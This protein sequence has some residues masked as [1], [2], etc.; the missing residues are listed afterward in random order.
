MFSRI[1]KLVVTS[2]LSVAA[3]CGSTA[4]SAVE[5][6]YP[7]HFTMADIDGEPVDLEQYKGKVVLLVNVAGKCGL[8]PQYEALQ[9]LYEKYGDRGFTIL[10][11]PA[12][13]FAEQEPG[14]NEE[15]KAF[16]SSNYGVNFPLFSKVSVK[17]E[18]ICP[19]YKYLTREQTNPGFSGEIS[20]NFT[21]FLL[22]RRGRVV[23]R[24]EPKTTPDDQA[25][26]S[27]IEKELAVR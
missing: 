19:L 11:F 24:F 8:T 5:L 20:W 23:G 26:V 18:D 12:N 14:T 10:A 6:N 9:A 27:A 15:I 3:A 17:G 2:V 21:K 13:N 7:L 25:V 16:C 22:D 1:F 4:E